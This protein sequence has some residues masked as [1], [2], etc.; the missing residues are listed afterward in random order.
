VLPLECINLA[1]EIC[2]S[3]K[4]EVDVEIWFNNL[5]KWLNFFKMID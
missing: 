5:G 3:H 2:V 1:G 4:K